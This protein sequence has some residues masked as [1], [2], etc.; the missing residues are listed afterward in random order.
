MAD[1]L[2][3]ATKPSGIEYKKLGYSLFVWISDDLLECRCSYIPR[4]QGSMIT[5][6]ELRAYVAQTSVNFGIDEEALN[7]FAVNGAAGRVLT[8]VLLASGEP[9]VHGTDGWISYTAEA[10]VVV[11]SGDDD[12]TSS[13]DMHNVQTFINVLPEEEIGRINR[14]VPGKFGRGINGKIIPPQPG[15][16]V[17]IK[18]GKNIRAEEGGHRLVAVSAGRV[19]VAS[20]EISV[21]EEYVVSGDV[22][23]HVGS[24]VFNGF[25]EVRG[26]VLDEFS[27]SSTKGIRITGNAGDCKL[28]SEGDISFCGMDGQDKGS[29]MCGG[30]IRSQFIHN[31]TIE[32]VGDVIAEV[33]IHNCKIKTLGRL[34]VNKGT[35]AGGNYIAL[36]GIEAK[37]IGS[38][39][40][41]RTRLSVG[42]DYHDAEELVH[43]FAELEKNQAQLDQANSLVEMEELRTQKGAL[44]DR[45]MELRTK[46]DSRANAKL[47]F[48][49]A[50]YENT[51]VSIGSL[52]EAINE[53]L[54]GPTSMIENTIEGGLRLLSMTSL[55]VKATDIEMAFVR[56]QKMKSK[57]SEL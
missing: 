14:P 51:K 46:N 44:T 40:S 15:K 33:E 37:K 48:K 55:D 34:V 5:A 57:A 1:D 56:E 18:I 4:E 25:V 21:E 52:N 30:S 53:Q 7:E 2:P 26:D 3:S 6:D 24:I 9:P 16:P 39:A 28:V 32:C 27:I 41:V 47:N 50:L 23:F 12:N 36:G 38:P 10:S 17:N 31:S 42:V 29:I 22:D 43:L 45:I 49:T 19:C 11:R 13:I 54:D 20:G 8:S 35:I